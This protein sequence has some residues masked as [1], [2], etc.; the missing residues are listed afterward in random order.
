MGL[1]GKKFVTMLFISLCLLSLAPQGNA[2]DGTEISAPILAGSE[3]G[4]TAI[5]KFGLVL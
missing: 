1:F 2:W 5:S 3:K 4:K